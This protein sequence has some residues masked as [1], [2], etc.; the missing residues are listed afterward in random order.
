MRTHYNL[1]WL[2]GFRKGIVMSIALLIT[3]TVANAQLSGTV[4]INS[5]ASTS[6]T[7][8]KSFAD[9]TSALSSKGISGALTVNVVSGSGPYS[10]RVT[11]DAVSGASATNTI[12]IKGNGEKLTNS[13]NASTIEFNG[14]DYF[15][16]DDLV[17][18]AAGTGTGVRCI[19][20][21]K[22]ANYNTVK[23]SEL[24][25]SKYTGTS[26][27]TGYIIFSASTSG[28]SAG[29]HGQHNTFDGNKMWNGGTSSSVGPYYGVCE[30]GSSSYYGTTGHN[31]FSNNY[32]SNIYYYGFYMYYANGYQIVGNEI[33]TWR[34][35]AS[36][37]YVTYCYYGNTTT[38]Q[39]RI[40][41]NKIH[42]ISAS[43]YVYVYSYRCQGTG[44]LPFEMSGNQ[45]YNCSAGYYVYG[46]MPYYATNLVCEDN[47]I[48]SNKA[49]Y[50]VYGVYS[51]YSQN[52]TVA[53]NSIHDNSADYGV[54]GYYCYYMTG[55]LINNVYYNNA[56]GYYN[57]AILGGYTQTNLNVCHNT[58][59]LNKDVDYYNYG[60]YLYM[61]YTF[62]DINVKNNIV[63][64]TANA[65]YYN[66]VI[67][68]YYH[69]QEMNFYNN[70][71]Y[72]KNSTTNYYYT[73][74]QNTTL[75]AFNNDVGN[76][77]NI[78]V[79]PNFKNLAN[80]DLTPT[81]PSIANYGQPGY[82]K[83][84]FL[85]KT[86]T[87][88]G[89]DIGA[90]EFTVDHSASNFTFSATDECG[91]YSEEVTFDFQNGVNVALKDVKVY[92]SIN[93]GDPVIE[94]ISSVAAN[95]KVTYTFE[96]IPEFHEPGKNTITVG[97]LCDDNTTNNTITKTINIT[98]APHS[99]ELSE[100]SNFPG[101]YRM[102]ASGGTFTNPDV[103]VPGKEI[104]YE[105]MNPSAYPGS[106]YG[107]DWDLTPTLFTSGGNAVTSGFKYNSPS[108]SSSGM[109]AFDPDK[110][111]A[112]S[113][114]F[115]GLSAYDYN[116]GC[117]SLFGRWVYIP[118]T[119][120]V[121]WTASAGCD[122]DV[123]AFT[124]GTKQ[125]KGLVEYHWNFN[126]P[127]TGEDSASTISDPVHLFS[128]YGTYNVTLEAWNYDYP[129]F[130]YTLSKSV[131]ISPKPEACFKVG[132]ACEGQDVQFL[133]CTTAPVA[134]TIDYIWN[135]G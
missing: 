119:P 63:V 48:K 31:V 77:T 9:L 125:S 56:G 68:A 107:S 130:V 115:V 98:P 93:G 39:I 102:G 110:S 44:S 29:Q 124:N 55:E 81:N 60:L 57:Y 43:Y 54:Y 34:N 67:Y 1:K 74:S 36:Y 17:I 27:S 88:C 128:T 85:Q 23:N 41:N 111:L 28:N 35:G 52:A 53:R 80:G 26:N 78:E 12:T 6:G 123:I 131:D 18:E 45:L 46:I 121:A 104:E 101:Y 91:G 10:E 3:G 7:N 65:Q 71:F 70:D 76:N 8:Y 132:N 49:G 120:D 4:T 86:R 22:G 5:G 94:T 37:A 58:F 122:G 32:I 84:D 97:L 118:V 134:G 108:G 72:V 51:Y 87:T 96:S 33:T 116:T 20:L 75:A 129:K 13:T 127:N 133:N 113:I 62:N 112:D 15:T 126:D 99:F 14:A 40:S 103:T 19:H 69:F 100:G 114:V 21:W 11:F 92:Y 73:S 25:I 50:Y 105:I 90:Y 64:M 38:D 79:D 95:G 117:D 106:T 16:I 89:P 83:D 61:Y 135:F 47:E 82:A 30:Y 66:Y 2:S 42:D 109:I 59:V 24:I